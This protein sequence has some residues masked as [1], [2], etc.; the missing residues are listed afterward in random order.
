MG[1]SFNPLGKTYIAR[2][3]ERGPSFRIDVRGDPKFSRLLH[4]SR[5]LF[6]LGYPYPLLEIHKA[7][8]LRDK[9]DYFQSKLQETMIRQGLA[10][11]YLSGVYHLEKEREEFHQV[12]DGLM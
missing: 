3:H 2:L 8:T 7:T 11:E 6:C 1:K 9:T 4:Y 10:R 12:I 5:Y